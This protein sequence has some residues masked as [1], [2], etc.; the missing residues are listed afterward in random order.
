MFFLGLMSPGF[1]IRCS[2][3]VIKIWGFEMMSISFL[4]FPQISKEIKKTPWLDEAFI[5]LTKMVQ[6]RRLKP[7]TLNI[8]IVGL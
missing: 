3:T 7:P 6:D 8:V 2:Y 5:C 1:D 4:Y